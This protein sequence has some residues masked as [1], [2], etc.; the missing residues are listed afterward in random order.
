MNKDYVYPA[1]MDKTK[2]FLT[3]SEQKKLPYPKNLRTLCST[4]NWDRDKNTRMEWKGHNEYWPEGLVYCNILK[5]KEHEST[6]SFIYS[7]ALGFHPSRPP[8]TDDMTYVDY[9]VP[10]SAIMWVDKPY[11]S[12]LHL[13]NSFR[14]PIGLPDYLVPEQ[15]WRE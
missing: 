7:V 13:K 6:G 14:H 8:A 12:D 4:T 9:N 5:R 3:V 10:H 1:D 11:T 2:P 15:Q